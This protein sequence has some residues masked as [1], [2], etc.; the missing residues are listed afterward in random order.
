MK[1]VLILLIIYLSL[2]IVKSI[3]FSNNTFVNNTM[4]INE[5][6][7][8]NASSLDE[9]TLKPEEVQKMTKSTRRPLP[10]M[11]NIWNRDFVNSGFVNF[12]M[13]FKY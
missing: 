9:I 4:T 8:N 11:S 13:S 3:D 2:I 10:G 1:L 7:Y 6:N 5:N 12:G